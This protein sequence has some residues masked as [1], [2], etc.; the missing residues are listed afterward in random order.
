MDPDIVG[1]VNKCEVCSFALHNLFE[2]GLTRRVAA[3]H[4]MLA[5]APEVTNMADRHPGDG[6]LDFLRL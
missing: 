1:R 4:Q 6:I 5:H 2:R 3:K